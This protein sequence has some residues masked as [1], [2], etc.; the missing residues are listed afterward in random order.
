MIKEKI[1]FEYDVIW[2][3]KDKNTCELKTYKKTFT[4]EEDAFKFRDSLR[5][6]EYSIIKT[7]YSFEGKR[8]IFN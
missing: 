8:Y 2:C 1:L 7:Y 6:T 5:N 4:T 3:I